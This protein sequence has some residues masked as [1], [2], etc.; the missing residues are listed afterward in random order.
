MPS[1]IIY[2][3]E[4]FDRNANFTELEYVENKLIKTITKE[5]EAKK[6]N[7]QIVWIYSKILTS[8]YKVFGELKFRDTKNRDD[9]KKEKCLEKIGEILKNKFNV[10]IRLRSFAIN[11]SLITALDL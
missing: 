4:N 3:D 5:L 2:I 1:L 11:D 9:I 8:K 6:D 10:K 7:C